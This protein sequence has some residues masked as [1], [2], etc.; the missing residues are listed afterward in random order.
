MPHYHGQRL[1]RLGLR[2]RL[3]VVV[4]AAGDRRWL[5][6]V[7]H[8]VV[9]AGAGMVRY[10]APGLSTREMVDQAAQTVWVCRAKRT[11]CLIGPCATIGVTCRSLADGREAARE[12]ASYVEVGEGLTGGL[13]EMA[14]A[15]RLARAVGQGTRLPVCLGNA[16]L[17]AAPI[18]REA[19]AL[20]VAASAVVTGSPNPQAMVRALLEAL[21]G[22]D[23][24]PADALGPAASCV[25]QSL[26]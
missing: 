17:A 11:L 14:E 25:R 8:R 18:F 10:G 9:A 1:A 4:N 20:L 23:I 2:S 15:L 12:G 3:V 22:P 16:T 21:E 6:D 26:S 5:R 19:P 7:V 13:E 24:Q